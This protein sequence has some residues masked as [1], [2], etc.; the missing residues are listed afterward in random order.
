ML[1]CIKW[2]R[3]TELVLKRDINEAFSEMTKARVNS[4]TNENT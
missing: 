3:A 1:H 4:L 2:I